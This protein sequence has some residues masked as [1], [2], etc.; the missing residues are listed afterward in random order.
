MLRDS[1]KALH[2]QRQY[3]TNTAAQY[4]AMHAHEAG[5]DYGN[6]KFI[7]ALLGMLGAQTVLDVG[8]G[9]GRGIRHL[10]DAIPNLTVR[11]I[12]PVPAL[13]EQAVQKNGIPEGVIVHGFGE[14]LPFGNKSFDIVCSFGILHHVPK[15]DAVVLEM[16]RVARMAVIISDSNRFGQGKPLMRLLKLILYKTGLW[17]IVNYLKTGGKGYLVSPGD[18]VA[19]SYSVYDSLG[20]VAEWADRVILIPGEVSKA[21]SWFHPLLTAGTV[22]VCALKETDSASVSN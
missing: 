14:A 8:A 19:Y 18:G 10:L 16:L 21:R 11:G 6:L 17:G 12:E 20:Y 5:D 3:Y 13:I 2:A 22:L 9:T 4:D 1:D 15:P 7:C